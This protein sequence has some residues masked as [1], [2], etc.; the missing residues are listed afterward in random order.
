MLVEAVL[1][2]VMLAG[3]VL[4]GTVVVGVGS[5]AGAQS[6]PDTV[7]AIARLDPAD[8]SA[9][10]AV[11][12]A[13]LG[14]IDDGRLDTAELNLR[15]LLER[16]EAPALRDLLGVVLSRQERYEEAEKELLRALGADPELKPAREHL[17]R[18][19]L[20][21]GRQQ[22]ALEELRR[23]AE[24]GELDREL[25]L[26]LA[27]AE[28]RSGNPA[29]AEAQLRSVAERFDSVRALLEWARL[30][31]DRGDLPTALTVLRRAL[32][33][34]PASEA[35]LGAFAR[36]SLRSNLPVPAIQV[37]EPLHRMHPTVA[38]YPYLLGVARL[39]VA[40][41]DRAITSLDESIRIDPERPLPW[42]ALGIAYNKRS[43]HGE[44]AEVLLR[45]LRLAPENPEALA[46][47]AEAEEGRGRRGQAEM[48][49]GRVPR[50]TLEASVPT[51][52]SAHR[53]LGSV[54]LKRGEP[55][56]AREALD[57]AVALEP[58]SPV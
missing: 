1:L 19:Y 10:D 56:T 57:Q 3:T 47:L 9:I 18:L 40:D 16:V 55:T 44:A 32:G 30:A 20:I 6:R 37:L 27:S 5:P 50:S 45:A 15:A 25:A 58:S 43:R 21:L 53:V 13:I 24:L 34:A 17:G 29:A 22:D 51:R 4:V 26:S 23:A 36:T 7:P 54:A 31:T 41:L 12:D 33:R 49:A 46:A 38:E 8:A 52:A 48:L 2:G 39:Q 14:A 28:E 11:V 35:V 42:I